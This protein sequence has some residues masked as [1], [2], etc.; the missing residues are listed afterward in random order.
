MGDE[1]KD[2]RMNLNEVMPEDKKEY[3]RPEEVNKDTSESKP[4]N[5]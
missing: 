2:E 1:K 3:P 5:E 4:L